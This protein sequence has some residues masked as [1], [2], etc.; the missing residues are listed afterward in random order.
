MQ[1]SQRSLYT[2]SF[3]EHLLVDIPT[4]YLVIIELQWS[5]IL[6]AKIWQDSQDYI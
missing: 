3:S 2:K 1:S 5:S 6:M 4:I